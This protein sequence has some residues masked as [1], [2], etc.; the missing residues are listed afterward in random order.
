MVKQLKVISIA[1]CVAVI[2]S[3]L[4]WFVARAAEQPP[5]TT[6][7]QA[8][9]SRPFH[10]SVTVWDR[11]E[12]RQRIFAGVDIPDGD[13]VNFRKQ[14]EVWFCS[15]QWDDPFMASS[16]QLLESNSMLPLQ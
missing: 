6:I 16:A 7:P 8:S 10:P 1:A 14:Q 12:C 15:H 2:L 9:S 4:I 11:E 13:N 5:Y 3:T